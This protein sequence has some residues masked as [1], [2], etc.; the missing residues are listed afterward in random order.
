MPSNAARVC[1][2]GESGVPCIFGVFIQFGHARGLGP[3][4]ASH[5]EGWTHYLGRLAEV[6]AGRVPVRLMAATANASTDVEVEAA[7][8]YFSAL[9]P[10][11]NL[12]VIETDE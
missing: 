10:Q 11:A 8:A 2:R 7:A 4:R 3:G 9:K 5:A 12:T 6:A 1:R